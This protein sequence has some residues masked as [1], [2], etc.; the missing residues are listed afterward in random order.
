MTLAG[1][2]SLGCRSL[3]SG[4]ADVAIDRTKTP[5]APIPPPRSRSCWR[6]CIQSPDRVFPYFEGF[7]SCHF[8]ARD[9]VGRS[10]M[11]MPKQKN[12]HLRGTFYRRMLYIN[13]I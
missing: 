1:K 4:L 6:H 13:E 3:E 10:F 11:L 12:M 8:K 5:E 9:A 7:W 2:E